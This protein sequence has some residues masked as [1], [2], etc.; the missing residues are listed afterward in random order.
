[1]KVEVILPAHIYS[2][3][4]LGSAMESVSHNFYKEQVSLSKEIA[5]MVRT[6]EMIDGFVEDP[7][8]GLINYRISMR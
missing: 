7:H 2:P 3:V 5:A 1:M 4:Q 8:I 6:T